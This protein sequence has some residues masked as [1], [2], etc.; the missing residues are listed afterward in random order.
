MAFA[1]GIPI[2]AFFSLFFFCVI[3][4]CLF[5]LF[6]PVEIIVSGNHKY[7]SARKPQLERHRETILPHI[8]VQMPV[9]KEGLQGV[10]KPT[11]DSVTAAIRQYEKRGGT[12]NFFIADDGMQAIAPDL[13][14]AR[15]R[16]YEYMGIGW[17]SRPKHQY[18]RRKNKDGFNRRGKFKKA[19]NL[20]YCLDFSL[21]VEVRLEELLNEISQRDDCEIEEIPDAV[22]QSSFDRA[23]AEEIEKVSSC[24][25]NPY[26]SQYTVH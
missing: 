8:T 21:R 10:I 13:A 9:Y 20:N 26:S 18:N 11:V 24:S 5:F 12:A 25:M 15:Q 16:Y 23:M 17:C 1:T 22:Q 19:S 2:Y 3:V 14:M 4:G 6:G 7:Y